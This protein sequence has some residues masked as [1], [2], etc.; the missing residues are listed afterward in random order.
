MEPVT[1]YAT[2]V[3]AGLRGSRFMGTCE[4]F[5]SDGEVSVTGHRMPLWLVR[6]RALCYVLFVPW[7]F[8]TL[9]SVMAV[10]ERFDGWLW[11]L[12]IE[13]PLT[14]AVFLGIG[15]GDIWVVRRGPVETVTWRASQASTPRYGRDSTQ[16]AV[17]MVAWEIV[18]VRAPIGP[19]G[20]S[21]VLTLRAAML[22]DQTL[23]ESLKGGVVGLTSASS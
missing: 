4:V 19:A 5:G 10:S 14:L 18:S 11:V 15:V 7:I 23:V 1:T 17:P 9:A 8:V 6:V 22:D 16:G 12:A 21:R 3:N 2:Y 20:K 13:V